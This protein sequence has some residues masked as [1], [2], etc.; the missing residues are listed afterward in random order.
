LYIVVD[1]WA[2]GVF[3]GS[4]RNLLCRSGNEILIP[5]IRVSVK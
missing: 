4:Q 2:K 3:V 1:V 5:A